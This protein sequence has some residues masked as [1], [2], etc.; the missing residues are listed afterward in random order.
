MK[1]SATAWWFGA[2]ALLLTAS[3]DS[4]RNAT[5]DAT[6]DAAVSTAVESTTPADVTFSRDLT[7][8]DYRF[9]VQSASIDNGQQ[10]TIRTRRGDALVTDPIRMNVKGNVTDAIMGDLNGNGNPELYVIT[11]GS[12]SF[13]GVEAYEFVERAFRPVQAP[14][15]L[16]NDLAAGYNGQ[17][18]YE[19]RGNRLVRTFPV[20]ATGTA[21]GTTTAGDAGTT[22]TGSTRTIEYTL[23][24]DGMLMPVN[25]PASTDNKR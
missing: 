11:S 14:P 16:S 1:F 20:A 4:A 2:A 12:G 18:K 23:N 13:G 3:C 7:Q 9:Q 17:D 25:T 10:L 15:K 22:A 24:K 19:I 21:S 8:G 6:S 5:D